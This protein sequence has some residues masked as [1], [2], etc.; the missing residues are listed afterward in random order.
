MKERRQISSERL[1]LNQ[2]SAAAAAVAATPEPPANIRVVSRR[3]RFNRLSLACRPTSQPCKMF[4]PANYLGRQKVSPAISGWWWWGWWGGLGRPILPL[5]QRPLAS[6]N[7]CS[8]K[9]QGGVRARRRRAFSFFFSFF[10]LTAD[11]KIKSVMKG[12]VFWP[13]KGLPLHQIC[14]NLLLQP[15]FFP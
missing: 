8:T 1:P 3:R 7:K 13:T 11:R 12:E 2:R 4:C 14:H 15:C 9:W 10:L 6:G 5:H